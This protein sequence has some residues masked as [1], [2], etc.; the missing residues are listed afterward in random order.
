MT[1]VVHFYDLEKPRT[2]G[3]L[4]WIL[5]DA[6][7]ML[8]KPILSQENLDCPGTNEISNSMWVYMAALVAPGSAWGS[9]DFKI[10]CY[11]NY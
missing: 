8:L 3:I 11:C 10:E 4:K 1:E 2:F 7:A 6:G 5:W 9:L